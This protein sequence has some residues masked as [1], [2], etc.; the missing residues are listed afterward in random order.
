MS[1]ILHIIPH[2]VF[3]N[4][5]QGSYKDV[6][7]RVRLLENNPNGYRQVI[8]ESHKPLPFDE[9]LGNMQPSHIL[10]EYS[11]LGRIV[12]ALRL[13]YPKAFIAVRAHNIEPL[14]QFDNRGWFPLRKLPQ[15]LYSCLRLLHTDWMSAR[16]ADTIYSINQWE[17]ENYWNKMPGCN[18]VHWLPYFTP[19]SMLPKHYVAERNI[20]ACLPSS[21]EHRKTRDL[22]SRFARFAE[23]A[24]PFSKSDIFAVSGDLSTWKMEIPSS[25]E[26]TGLIGDL[27][28]YMARVKAVALLSPLGYGFK[29]TIADAIA[30]GCYVIVHPSIY[31]R[32][33]DMLRPACIEL[34]SLNG[35]DISQVL[36]HIEAP[37]PLNHTMEKLR[38]ITLRRLETDFCFSGKVIA[39]S[40]V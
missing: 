32:C 2:H 27:P 23:A 18:S 37:F 36:K 5:Y 13:R 26:L 22:V 6:I 7:G 34:R 40:S 4:H 15:L 14:Q 17:A 30:A 38:E 35:K 8:V 33:P 39:N 3:L 16:N 11:S 24:K 28:S 25:I 31:K 21:L 1:L 10:V 12:A 19:D 20:I 9:L 29:T